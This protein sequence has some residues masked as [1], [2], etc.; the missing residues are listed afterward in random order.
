TREL[1]LGLGI[2]AEDFARPGHQAIWSGTM[3]ILARGHAVESAG[4]ATELVRQGLRAS[5]AEL[6]DV[7]AN[8]DASSSS[9]AAPLAARIRELAMRRRLAEAADRLRALADDPSQTPD[10]SALEVS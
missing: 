9:E 4:L 10:L 7:E 1:A 2:G 6:L 3:G 8:A 5:A